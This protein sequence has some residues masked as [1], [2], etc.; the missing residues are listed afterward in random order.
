VSAAEP[1]SEAGAVRSRRT[2]VSVGPLLSGE[3][4]SGAEGRVAAP[5]PS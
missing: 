4:R 1:T 3:V 2:R 5:D